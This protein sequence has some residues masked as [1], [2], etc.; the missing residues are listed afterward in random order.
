MGSLLCQTGCHFLIWSDFP[1]R[2]QKGESSAFISNMHV[3]KT[4]QR[5][6]SVFSILLVILTRHF[7]LV[8]E[9]SLKICVVA[10]RLKLKISCFS[11][12][13]SLNHKW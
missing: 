3:F 12:A 5:G 1:G 2:F 4:L 13:G 8:S 6:H 9:M 7:A 10:E 11:D